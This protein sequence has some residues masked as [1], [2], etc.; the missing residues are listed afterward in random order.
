MVKAKGTAKAAPK[1]ASK[2]VAK[3]AK[4][5]S[6]A[7]TEADAQAAYLGALAATASLSRAAA[8]AGIAPE[9]AEAWRRADPG[10]AVR[11][12]AAIAVGT[13]ALEDEAV[14]RAHEGTVKPVFYRGEK[15]GQLRE[16][17]DGLLLALLKARRPE[18]FKDHRVHEPTGNVTI[19]IITGVSNSPEDGAGAAAPEDRPEGPGA[20]GQCTEDGDRRAGDG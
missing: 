11:H 3:A 7:R 17:S 12:E 20:R 4:T 13:D 5:P 6:A 18:K 15:L 9:A 1:T 2:T 16:Y 8:A 14:R 10:F 19:N